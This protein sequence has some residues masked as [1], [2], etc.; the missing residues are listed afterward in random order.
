MTAMTPATM[1]PAAMP[2]LNAMNRSR[3]RRKSVSSPSR[4]AP[5]TT[6]MTH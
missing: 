6:V 4:T 2:W 5:Q 3:S 1:V